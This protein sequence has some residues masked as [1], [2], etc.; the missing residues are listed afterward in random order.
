MIDWKTKKKMLEY[1]EK[2]YELE[3]LDVVK[4]YVDVLHKVVR[5]EQEEPK[6]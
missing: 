3:Q 6:K 1:A 5:F 4:E 2:L